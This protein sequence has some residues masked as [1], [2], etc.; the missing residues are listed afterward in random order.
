[1]KIPFWV[2]NILNLTTD[3][4][5]FQWQQLGSAAGCGGFARKYLRS[6]EDYAIEGSFSI[7]AIEFVNNRRES[8]GKEK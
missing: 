1:M 8:N 7:E 4:S 3:T 5:L 2:G 6:F